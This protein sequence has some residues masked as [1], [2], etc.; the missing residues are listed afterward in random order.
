ME[1]LLLLGASGTGKGTLAAIIASELGIGF[2][3]RAMWQMIGV[4]AEL[5]KSLISERRS[6]GVKDAQRRMIG[7]LPALAEPV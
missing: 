7:N 6:A 4:L 1:S 3:G 2:T 5:E